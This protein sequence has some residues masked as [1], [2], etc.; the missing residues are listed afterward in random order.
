MQDGFGRLQQYLASIL[1]KSNEQQQQP[2]A[3]EE[4]ESLHTILDHLE[5]V[6]HL[7]FLFYCF[8][9]SKTCAILFKEHAR[10]VGNYW[11]ACSVWFRIKINY[12]QMFF[13]R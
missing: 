6:S 12:C 8:F 7:A 11:I 5:H 9:L 1:R 4:A 13:C 10:F 2:Q 3:A